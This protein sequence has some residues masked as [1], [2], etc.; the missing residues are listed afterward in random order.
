MVSHYR[1]GAAA[2]RQYAGKPRVD[3]NS[4]GIGTGRFSRRL[5]RHRKGMGISCRQPDGYSYAAQGSLSAGGVVGKHCLSGPVAG[6]PTFLAGCAVFLRKGV[7]A[8]PQC[9]RQ[10]EPVDAC[11]LYHGGSGLFLQYGSGTEVS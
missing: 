4:E 9:G 11:F 6:L 5:S 8:R 2:V 1:S 10:R 7:L 3:K